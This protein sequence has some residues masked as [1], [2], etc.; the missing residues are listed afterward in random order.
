[1]VDG[2]KSFYQKFDYADQVSALNLF[3]RLFETLRLK[4]VF[5]KKVND[6]F[7]KTLQSDFF[8]Y[9]LHEDSSPSCS[10]HL[11]DYSSQWRK[12]F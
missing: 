7:N 5:L 1:M 3:T 6:Y 8:E 11:S 4:N 2:L 9:K 10:L 12:L